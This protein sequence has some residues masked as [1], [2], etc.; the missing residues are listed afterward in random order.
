MK[1]SPE[2]VKVPPQAYSIVT[3]Y[4]PETKP[5]D[6]S[7]DCRPLLVT[8]V[9]QS[10]SGA[11]AVRVCYGTTKL[12]FP[13]KAN[14]DLIVQNSSDLD[15]CG[16][17]RPTRFVIDPSQQTVLLWGDKYFEPWSGSKHPRRGM[18]PLD[19]QKEFAWLMAQHL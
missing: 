3:G 2:W 6:G 5:K 10:R 7:P 9:L 4:F 13:Q 16:L 1:N 8:Q 15:G 14:I 12:K 19:L 18:L 17:L 11:T